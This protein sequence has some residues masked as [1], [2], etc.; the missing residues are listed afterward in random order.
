MNIDKAVVETCEL[1]EARDTGKGVVGNCRDGSVVASVV[2]NNQM[3]SLMQ[4]PLS[5][6]L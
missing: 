2:W 6:L 3:Y 5:G 4:M 1:P